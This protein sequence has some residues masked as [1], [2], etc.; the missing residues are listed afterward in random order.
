M[1]KIYIIYIENVKRSGSAMCRDMDRWIRML[2]P[3]SR[4]PA[5]VP[6]MI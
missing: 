3:Q 6:S 1:K 2:W 5:S 4:Y